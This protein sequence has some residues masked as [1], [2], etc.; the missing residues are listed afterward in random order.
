LTTLQWLAMGLAL[1][2]LFLATRPTR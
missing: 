1:G 2:G